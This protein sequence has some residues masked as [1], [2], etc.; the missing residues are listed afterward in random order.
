MFPFTLELETLLAQREVTRSLQ[1]DGILT[2]V[3]V[4]PGHWLP[5]PD[6]SPGVADRL[7]A[8]GCSGPIF[9]DFRRAAVR[10][11]ERPAF[12]GASR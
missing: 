11:L 2:P 6:V 9:H 8:G 7:S 4:S 5:H 12:P 1:R 10:N 3:V